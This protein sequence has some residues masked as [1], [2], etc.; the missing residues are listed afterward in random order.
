MYCTWAQ[1]EGA[2]VCLQRQLSSRPGKLCHKIRGKCGGAYTPR[3]PRGHS[4][5]N[6]LLT[7]GHN[8]QCAT[9]GPIMLVHILVLPCQPFLRRKNRGNLESNQAKHLPL[10][11]G[12]DAVDVALDIN[13]STYNNTRVFMDDI[14]KKNQERKHSYGVDTIHVRTISYYLSLN[15]LPNAS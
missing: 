11:S 1:L 10:R 8:P 5:R 15:F 3:I 7:L 6:L 9:Y 2:H 14:R 13:F 12:L 4:N